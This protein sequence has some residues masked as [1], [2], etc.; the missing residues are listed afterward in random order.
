MAEALEIM[1][2]KVL[3]SRLIVYHLRLFYSQKQTAMV[4]NDINF[5]INAISWWYSYAL[6]HAICQSECTLHYPD[7]DR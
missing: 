7:K 4:T 5:K 1:Q 6:S 3:L 2:W